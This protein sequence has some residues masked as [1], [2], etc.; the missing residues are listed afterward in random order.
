M[1]QWQ[2]L[3]DFSDYDKR[4]PCSLC[5]SESE[6]TLVGGHFK[7]GVCSHLF[8]EDASKLDIEC[9]CDVCQKK[10]QSVGRDFDDP[11]IKKV[12]SSMA[13]KLKKS[14]KKPKIKPLEQSIIERFGNG[15]EKK[16]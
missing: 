3:N 7:C 1:G 16:K 8:N 14:K 4:I 2:E 11:K 15:K 9:Y 5:K 12:L 13:K 10:E 6:P